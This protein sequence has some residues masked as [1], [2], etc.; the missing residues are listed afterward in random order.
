MNPLP[1]VVSISN[2][3]GGTGKTTT[4][5]NL[6]VEF[7]QR[8]YQVLLIDLDTQGHAAVGLDVN[9]P[10]GAPTAQDMFVQPD[11]ALVCAIVP[12]LVSGLHFVPADQN[13][14]H[15][16]GPKDLLVL[17]RQIEAPAIAE[18]YDIIVIDTPPSLDILLMN[19]MAA[20]NGILIPML[21]HH[22]SGEGVRQ[23][24]RLFFRI[25]SSINPHLQLLGLLPV[26]LER[27]VECHQSVLDN[28]SLQYGRQRLLRGI[29]TDIRLAEAFAARKPIQLYSPRSRGSLDYYVLAEDLLL[30]WQ[31]IRGIRP[32]RP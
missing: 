19:A 26:M 29:R 30:M 16:G 7:A 1:F 23:L 3:K 21:P 20:A 17:R 27:G 4:A 24:S 31:D 10:R 11:F 28:I 18:H 2:R 32:Q 13:F 15:G 5:V 9:C 22:L 25:G 14:E 6:A 12:T 8:D